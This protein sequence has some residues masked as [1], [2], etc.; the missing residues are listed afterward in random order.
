M[1]NIM[2]R[3]FLLL[4]FFNTLLFTAATNATVN[5]NINQSQRI[6]FDPTTFFVT[7]CKQ[8]HMLEVKDAGNRVTIKLNFAELDKNKITWAEDKS[9]N[10]SCYLEDGGKTILITINESNV[11]LS[12]TC[13]IEKT[14]ELSISKSLPAY[15][16]PRSI[17]IERDN[18]NLIITLQ[19]RGLL[20]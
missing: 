19:K 10:I 7:L 16:K 12:G 18:N 2:K 4:C 13:N 3:L 11:T 20:W 6:T 5:V 8:A 9:G 14:R 17:Q 1:R 15:V